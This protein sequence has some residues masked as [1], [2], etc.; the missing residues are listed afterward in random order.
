M[1]Q[2]SDTPVRSVP[3]TAPARR[4]PALAL[5][6]SPLRL[7]RDADPMPTA[8]SAALAELAGWLGTETVFVPAPVAAAPV[9]APWEGWSP[10]AFQHGGAAGL[11]NAQFVA[12]YA[13]DHAGAEG[14]GHVD[15]VL[16]SP[17][18]ATCGRADPEAA[19]LPD[20]AT[21]RA[22]IRFAVA[23]G[24]ARIAIIGDTRQCDALAALRLGEDRAL[25][26]EW[27]ALA[28]LAIEDAL[29]ALMVPGA[30]WDAIIAMPDL[31]GIIFTL[32]AETTGVR[33]PWPML[34]HKRGLRHVTSEV[35]DEVSE[36]LPLDAPVLIQTLA[37]TLQVAGR[38]RCASR[39]HEGW[40]RL[41]ASGVTTPSRGS[42][43][44]YA[45]ELADEDL[46][47]LLCAN[48]GETGRPVRAW[49]AL[50]MQPVINS[51]SQI[52]SLRVISANLANH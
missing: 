41:R 31:R 47:A 13:I 20:T 11:P 39:L 28:K 9:F 5:V 38:S 3:Q 26:P 52:P 43:A 1:D 23:E 24:R 27:V 46:I 29:P 12:S 16:I 2:S 48:S 7:A 49:Q 14:R 35:R 17:H 32:L 22:M 44:P 40:A 51:G 36:H 15:K 6:S 33:G 30:P 21:L 19:T 4:I 45:Q 10:A 42:A 37:L 8:W 50:K 18:P 25:V 34:W